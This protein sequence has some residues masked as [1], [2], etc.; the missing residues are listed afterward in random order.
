MSEKKYMQFGDIKLK[1]PLSSL[2]HAKLK[3]DTLVVPANIIDSILEFFNYDNIKY[4]VIENPSLYPKDKLRAGMKRYEDV[5]EIDFEDEDPVLLITQFDADT[6]FNWTLQLFGETIDSSYNQYLEDE[7][8][9]ADEYYR[10]Q[11]E[12]RP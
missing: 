11:Y 9:K 5:D 2:K 7:S 1:T 6:L 4:T 12:Y 10:T 8:E 3:N